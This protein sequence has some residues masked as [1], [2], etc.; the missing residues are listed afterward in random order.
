MNIYRVVDS[1]SAILYFLVLEVFR[2]I[3]QNEL[4]LIGMSLVKY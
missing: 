3:G 4:V 1:I 2:A